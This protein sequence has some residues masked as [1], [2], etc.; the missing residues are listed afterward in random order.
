MADGQ[1]GILIGVAVVENRS[2]S[3]KSA[4]T[5]RRFIGVF[6]FQNRD[7]FEI[8]KKANTDGVLFVHRG[9]CL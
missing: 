2:V 8:F 6:G 7:E 9:V 5:E 1:K 4:L 3:K